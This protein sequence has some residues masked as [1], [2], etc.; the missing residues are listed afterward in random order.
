MVGQ[1]A[2]RE[3]VQLPLGEAVEAPRALGHQL[4]SERHVAHER[5][6][7]AQR[8]LRAEL[9]L[10][11]LAHVMEDRRGQEE[12][13]VEP[14]MERA[15][16]EGERGHRHGVLEEAAEVGVVSRARA[17]RAAELVA[18]AGVAEERVEQRAQVGVVDLPPEVLEEAVELLDVAVGDRQELRRVRH[19]LRCA[20]DRFQLD[21]ELVAEALHATADRHEIASLEL[22]RQEIGVAERAAGDRAGA[23]AQ[24]DRQVRR[25]VLGGQ[26][27]LASAREHPLDLTARSQLRNGHVPIVIAGSDVGY[28]EVDDRCDLARAS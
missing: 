8:D 4:L 15:G 12:V 1:D 27:V 6:R 2:V 5:A 16:L 7:L 17:R 24:L 20:L 13:G 14:R 26:A 3:S 25:A 19:L 28:G 11:C 9:K 23:V 21:L 10:E 22:A 18:K